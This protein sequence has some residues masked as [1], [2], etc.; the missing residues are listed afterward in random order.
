MKMQRTYR[1]TC[2]LPE[3]FGVNDGTYYGAYAVGS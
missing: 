1:T 3:L 2:A